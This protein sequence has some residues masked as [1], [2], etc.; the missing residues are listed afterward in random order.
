M[1]IFFGLASTFGLV[2]SLATLLATL[3]IRAKIDR[4]LGKQR[5]LQQREILLNQL[6]RIRQN[7]RCMDE[8]DCDLDDLLLNL[9]E[10]LLQLVNYRIWRPVDRIRLKQFIDFLSKT[11]NGQKQCSCKEHIMRI[12]E[13]VAMVKAQAEV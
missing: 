11:Y 13:I 9:R 3:N 12:D 5:F 1:E 8:N 2:F 10:L 4:S 7:I 6:V